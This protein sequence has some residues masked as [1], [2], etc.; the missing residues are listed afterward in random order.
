M[1]SIEQKH[2]DRYHLLEKLHHQLEG[3]LHA[4][5]DILVVGMS[6]GFEP[7]YVK[8]LFIYLKVNGYIEHIGFG[9]HVKLTPYGLRAAERMVI[10]A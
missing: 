10:A 3:S 4:H 9:D 1:I 6:I 7:E 8:E 2:L 5:S